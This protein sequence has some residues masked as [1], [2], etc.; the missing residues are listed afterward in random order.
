MDQ[1]IVFLIICGLAFLFYKIIK[2]KSE[3]ARLEE[4]I[5]QRYNKSAEPDIVSTS[6]KET[7]FPAWTKAWFPND[8]YHIDDAYSDELQEQD[9]KWAFYKVMDGVETFGADLIALNRKL[10]NA[11][12][13]GSNISENVVLLELP[14]GSWRWPEFEEYWQEILEETKHEALEETSQL[15]F[16]ELLLRLPIYEI[17]NIKADQ[18]LP[19]PKGKLKKVDLIRHIVE[20]CPSAQLADSTKQAQD[21]LVKRAVNRQD[22]R[23]ERV[24]A[25]ALSGYIGGYAYKRRDLRQHLSPTFTQ[26]FPELTMYPSKYSHHQKCK[27]FSGNRRYDDPAW[28]HDYP[29]HG[30][31]CQCHV[32]TKRKILGKE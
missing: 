26:I 8:Q 21:I 3:E 29:P 7:S 10:F 15:S 11:R 18:H 19:P 23:H 6:K 5:K 24:R 17:N 14:N 25:S 32:G 9:Y 22:G 28:E 4:W 16:S 20:N 31:G 12:N 27:T 30:L 13:E 2:T 1:L